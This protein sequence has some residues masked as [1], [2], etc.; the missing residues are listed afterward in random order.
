M[1]SRVREFTRAM[2]AEADLSV[3]SLYRRNYALQGILLDIIDASQYIARQV[4]IPKPSPELLLKD[5]RSL[6]GY[7]A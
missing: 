5:D 1:H 7:L 4:S 6:T 2:N 3:N